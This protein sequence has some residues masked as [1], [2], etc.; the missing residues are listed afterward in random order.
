VVHFLPED[1]YQV[2][3]AG[4]A[5]VPCQ[6]IIVQSRIAP[7]YFPEFLPYSREITGIRTRRDAAG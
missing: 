7:E 3:I 4:N 6:R 1:H 5:V 2:A